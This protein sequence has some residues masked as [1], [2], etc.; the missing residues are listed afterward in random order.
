MEGTNLAI[1]EAQIRSMRNEEDR[2]VNMV[3][4]VKEAY[5]EFNL[6]EIA[7]E[8]FARDRLNQ[9]MTQEEIEELKLNL[10]KEYN[11]DELSQEP[12]NTREESHGTADGIEAI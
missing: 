7:F 6:P 4:L 3:N 2:L 10:N 11:N 9:P 5:K 8:W 1:R 12:A